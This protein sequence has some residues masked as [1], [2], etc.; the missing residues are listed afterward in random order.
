MLHSSVIVTESQIAGRGLVATAFIA[1]GTLVWQRDGHEIIISREEVLA[2]P[3]EEQA[4]Y[5]V[6]EVGYVLC[7]DG[8]QYMN[9]SCAPNLAATDNDDLI[10]ARDIHPGE[11]VTY[12]YGLTEIDPQLRPAWHCACGA[13]HCRRIIRPTDVLLPD[14]QKRYAG[15]ISDW[16]IER[17]RQLNGLA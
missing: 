17:C 16:I 10:A 3:P 12:D 5:Y 1:K 7:R 2:L 11:E 8:S 4:H 14:F 9:H 15:Q 13:D 6:D